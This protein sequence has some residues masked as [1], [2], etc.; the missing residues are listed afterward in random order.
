MTQFNIQTSRFGNLLSN[1]VALSYGPAANPG[2]DSILISVDGAELSVYGQGRHT[3]GVGRAE[4]DKGA[5]EA[6]ACITRDQAEALASAIGKLSKAKDATLIVEIDEDGRPFDMEDEAGQ[7][8]TE[9]VN[10]V[11][12]FENDTICA[13]PDSDPDA[14]GGTFW[15]HIDEYDGE[16]PDNPAWEGPLAL[17][18]RSLVMLNKLKPPVDRVDVRATS[19]PNIA[20]VKYGETTVLLG[21]VDR[22]KGGEDLWPSAA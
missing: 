11:V 3:A 13:L 8:V 5:G 16:A 7:V 12:T 9:V 10:L 22:G 18:T 20:A 1:A 19:N 17:G 4:L 6:S 14:A 21:V 2:F 15:D